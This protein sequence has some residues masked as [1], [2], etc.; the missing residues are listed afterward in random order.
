MLETLPIAKNTNKV[1]L[2]DGIESRVMTGLTAAALNIDGNKIRS[3]DCWVK[4]NNNDLGNPNA[5]VYEVGS[6]SLGQQMSFRKVLAAKDAWR[7]QWFG[8]FDHDIFTPYTNEWL[9]I[10]QSF[11]GLYSELYL[12]GV[13]MDRVL[14]DTLNTSDTGPYA[15]PFTIGTW[16]LGRYLAGVSPLHS[17]KG[18]IRDVRVWD[19]YKTNSDLL[20]LNETYV[21]RTNPSLK[22]WFTLRDGRGTLAYDL[23]GKAAPA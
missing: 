15:V 4:M 7:V 20:H 6:S 19:E 10:L 1:L 23:T 18:I 13:L 16:N 21:S 14:R 3:V 8:S 17:F 5:G 22:M 12:N 11:D 2:L 9:H